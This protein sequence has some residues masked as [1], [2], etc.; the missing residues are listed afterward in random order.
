[1]NLFYE[2]ILIRRKTFLQ[3]IKKVLFEKKKAVF[4]KVLFAKTISL[5]MGIEKLPAIIG[6][7]FE[8][9]KDFTRKTNF[10]KS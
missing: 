2:K 4:D 9:A 10:V 7:I 3:N 1:M 6:A 8:I 5:K